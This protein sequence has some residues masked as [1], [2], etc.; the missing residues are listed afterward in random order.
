MKQ[1][2]LTII[3][4]VLSA[5]GAFAQSGSVVLTYLD[6]KTLVVPVAEAP[7]MTINGEDLYIDGNT[8]SFSCRLADLQEYRFSDFTEGI[9]EVKGNC[10]VDR[11]GDVFRISAFGKPLEVLLFSL[12]GVLIRKIDS[13]DGSGVSLDISDIE[14]GIYLL[15]INGN[16]IKIIR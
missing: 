5:V 3:S 2:Y 8:S 6:G 12:Q 9:G 15:S 13:V 16:A 4:I 14:P 1:I 7:V 11:N 10:T